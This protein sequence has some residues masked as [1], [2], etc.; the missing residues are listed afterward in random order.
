MIQGVTRG[1]LEMMKMVSL[2]VWIGTR[3]DRQFA[4]KKHF[5]LDHCLWVE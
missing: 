4:A 3:I 5:L 2:E 1:G